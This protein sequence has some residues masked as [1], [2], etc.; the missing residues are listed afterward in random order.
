MDEIVKKIVNNLNEGI[1]EFPDPLIIMLLLLNIPKKTLLTKKKLINAEIIER[2]KSF[3][4][5]RIVFFNLE[6]DIILTIF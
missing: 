1:I 6:S 4:I 3:K 2:K 5:A